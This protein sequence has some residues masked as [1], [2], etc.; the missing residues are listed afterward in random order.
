M[1]RRQLLTLSVLAPFALVACE[2]RR[3]EASG[4]QAAASNFT[5]SPEG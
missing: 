5:Y 2:G 4:G 1:R 3:S